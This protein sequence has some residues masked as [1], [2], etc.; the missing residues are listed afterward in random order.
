M[1]KNSELTRRREYTCRN[2]AVRVLVSWFVSSG[3]LGSYFW[4]TDGYMNHR[5]LS[6]VPTCL[7]ICHGPSRTGSRNTHALC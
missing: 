6:T 7:C 1:T 4:K 2:A 5:I 3:L